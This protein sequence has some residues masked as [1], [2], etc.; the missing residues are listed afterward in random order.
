MER[1]KFNQLRSGAAVPSTH[2]AFT[3]VSGG[4]GD[5]RRDMDEGKVAV[6]GLRL[7]NGLLSMLSTPWFRL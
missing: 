6:P 5:V 1:I 3:S 7:T 2:F 4:A